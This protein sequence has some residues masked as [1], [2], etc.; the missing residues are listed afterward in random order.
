YSGS[1]QV[2]LRGPW[3]RIQGCAFSAL[4][5]VRETDEDSRI[6]SYVDANDQVHL[7]AFM[8]G[9]PSDNPITKAVAKTFCK[10]YGQGGSQ[11]SDISCE[12][13]DQTFIH[14]VNINDS[15]TQTKFEVSVNY[16]FEIV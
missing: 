8:N 13:G 1:D 14:K 11:Y 2:V 6:H 3:G 10:T 15:N 7:S 16:W 9:Q 4:E 12:L 5:N